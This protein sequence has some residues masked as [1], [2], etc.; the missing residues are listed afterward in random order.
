MEL[1]IPVKDV[2]P[3]YIFFA[4]KRKN[5]I[6]DGNFIKIIYSTPWFE[7]NGLYI[8]LELDLL[9][10]SKLPSSENH[11]N[12][13]ESF[14]FDAS[15]SA[16]PAN[17]AGHE[18][19]GVRGFAGEISLAQRRESRKSN[20]VFDYP[21]RQDITRFS[22]DAPL[23]KISDLLS[24]HSKSVNPIILDQ[25]APPGL[26]QKHQPKNWAQVGTD[27]EAG[28][29]IKR[30]SGDF[31]EVKSK[32]FALPL[33]NSD[34]PP[35]SV[36]FIK[37]GDFA[38]SV[39]AHL[40]KHSDLP[41][42]YAKSVNPIFSMY[43][44]SRRSMFLNANS[45]NNIYVIDRLCRVEQEIVDRYID[46][47]CPAKSA[48]YILKTQLLSGIIKYNSENKTPVSAHPL[49]HVGDLNDKTCNRSLKTGKCILKISGVWETA[50]NVGIT[51]KF[52][53]LS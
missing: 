49:K 3:Q 17:N 16:N 12:E 10:T 38:F 4:E 50:T 45:E 33:K 53:L 14:S 11:P 34:L 28:R 13:F 18:V 32:E 46:C 27:S 51:M 2:T 47:H 29:F 36:N 41:P 7:M 52:I 31:Y 5:V 6:V 8:F 25:R 19:I 48:S 35:S 9:H 21:H 22:F 40:L 20:I 44:E 43:E 15:K 39:D 26:V 37:S 24:S 23:L 42:S 30:N 1:S